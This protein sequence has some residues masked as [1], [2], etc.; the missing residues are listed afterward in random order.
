M[1]YEPDK[2]L[3]G[4]KGTLA[5]RP[6][7]QLFHAIYATRRTCGLE[8]KRQA[9][10]KVVI[11]ENGSPVG[12]TSNLV[13]ETL[14]RYLVDKRV[15]DEEA[16]LKLLAEAASR[17]LKLEKVLLEHQVIDE[18]TLHRHAQANLAQRI[19][20]AFR[21]SDARYRIL[22]DVDIAPD[23]P[24]MNAPQLL[25]TALCTAL[26]V[27]QVWAQFPL[28][29][30]TR[31]AIVHRPPLKFDDLKLAP[32]DRKL[33]EALQRRPSIDELAS[34]PDLDTDDVARR[35]YA[36]SLLGLVDLAERVPETPPPEPKR[37]EDE[38]LA[39]SAP[40][41]PAEP[42][43]PRRGRTGLVVGGIVAAAAA[44]ALVAMLL[45][46]QEPP[47]QLPPPAPPPPAPVVKVSEKPEGIK[48]PDPLPALVAAPE[49]A[50]HQPNRP[51]GL[52]LSASGI[53]LAPPRAPSKPLAAKFAL[54]ARQLVAG[55]ATVALPAYEA[56]AAKT[57]GSAEAQFGAAAALYML[58]RDAEAL[59]RANAA[60]EKNPAH[61]QSLLLTGFLA[62]Q[63]ANA[64]LARERFEAYLKAEPAGR[65]AA[66][67]RLIVEQIS[68]PAAQQ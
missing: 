29:G 16:H 37:L 30:S 43:P 32:R 63:S 41:A 56:L 54:A 49:G 35:L 52:T 40:V 62:L 42:P 19:L 61:A 53:T 25:F 39:S 15:M 11:F 3:R 51:R 9:F 67:V 1:F 10:E 8:L 23:A 48:P 38:A 34:L 33:I 66:D 20:D 46:R 26:P 18:A 55:K 31:F 47:A 4:T 17:E 27:E 58:G 5:E 22:G 24:R 7:P 68:E 50:L 44:G 36:F 13:H 14:G 59:A 45:P 28:E 12:C 57:R 64:D 6:L 60:L 2:I 21:W 65:W